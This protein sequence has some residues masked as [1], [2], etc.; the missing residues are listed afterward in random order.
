MPEKRD[1]T[2]DFEQELFSFYR[3]GPG[4]NDISEHDAATSVQFLRLSS[5]LSFWLNCLWCLQK[6]QINKDSHKYRYLKINLYFLSSTGK[7][8]IYYYLCTGREPMEEEIQRPK[9]NAPQLVTICGCLVSFVMMMKIEIY[10]VKSRIQIVPM[11]DQR[12]GLINQI[13]SSQ[14]ESISKKFLTFILFV[15]SVIFQHV[16]NKVPPEYLNVFPYK[17]TYHFFRLYLTNII[18]VYLYV[19]FLKK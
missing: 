12:M 6:Q 15:F 5:R 3:R 19:A 18:A 14:L 9:L 8:P 17:A 4:G 16:S 13:K 10:K 1:E 7:E 11:V 2:L